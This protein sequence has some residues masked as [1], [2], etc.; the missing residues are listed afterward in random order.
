MN[1]TCTFTVSGRG[2]FPY[3]ML[4]YDQCCPIFPNDASNIG[5]TDTGI[6]SQR[7]IQ[8][9]ST[10]NYPTVARWESFGWNVSN[11]EIYN[12]QGKHIS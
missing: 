12:S 11:I 6:D 8:F 5:R 9:N 7:D 1:R 4:R 10:K 2:R 3:D